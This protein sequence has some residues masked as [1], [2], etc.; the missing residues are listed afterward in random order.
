[1]GD[2]RKGLNFILFS[3]FWPFFFWGWSLQKDSRAAE[4]KQ[5]HGKKMEFPKQRAFCLFIYSRIWRRR[6]RRKCSGFLFLLGER[7]MQCEPFFLV[8]FFFWWE[9]QCEPMNEDHDPWVQTK[10]AKC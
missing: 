2:L 8:G 10:W 7:K 6:N 1:M 3:L 9:M 5:R 4:K